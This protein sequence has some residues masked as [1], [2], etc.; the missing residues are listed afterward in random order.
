MPR[1][2]EET[3]AM[4]QAPPNLQRAIDKK[5]NMAI[6]IHSNWYTT[7][8]TRAR[9]GFRGRLVI[10]VKEVR[11]SGIARGMPKYSEGVEERW[12][13]AQLCDLTSVYPVKVRDDRDMLPRP[14]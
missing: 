11:R 6:Q 2:T 7:G 5:A 9:V 10:Q 8:E 1:D 14:G 13:D 12:R 3:L 4:P